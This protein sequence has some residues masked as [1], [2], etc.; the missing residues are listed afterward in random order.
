MTVMVAV[1]VFPT[2]STAEA[3]T[4]FAPTESGTLRALNVE[5]E[6]KAR[7]PFTSILL[8]D[9]S[10]KVP[11]TLTRVVMN[12]EFFAGA[13]IEITGAIESR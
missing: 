9:A 2:R 8:R 3:V 11:L 6:M 13:V 10:V 5:P 7:R 1:E 4:V 12:E